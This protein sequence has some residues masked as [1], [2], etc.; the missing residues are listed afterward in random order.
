[1]PCGTPA[2]ARADSVQLQPHPS[3]HHTLIQSTMHLALDVRNV[4]L[5]GVHVGP[6]D[7]LARLLGWR[8]GGSDA[9]RRGHGQDGKQQQHGLAHPAA[10]AQAHRRWCEGACKC[11]KC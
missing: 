8:V 3:N 4:L 7:R 2:R 11:C 1:M 6:A 10:A 5:P 9:R